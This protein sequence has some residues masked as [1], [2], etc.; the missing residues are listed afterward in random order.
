MSLLRT[1]V[2]ACHPIYDRPVAPHDR[3]LEHIDMGQRRFSL[4]ITTTEDLER[5]AQIYN[6]APSSLSFFPSG[7]GKAQGRFL[8]MEGEDVLLSSLRRKKGKNQVTLFNTC[9][10]ERQV[11]LR[12]AGGQEPVEIALRGFELKI[13]EME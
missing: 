1:P 4:R 10:E 6:E 2:Y 7:E 13:M 3:C 12:R 8:E 9:E 5:Q 11:T